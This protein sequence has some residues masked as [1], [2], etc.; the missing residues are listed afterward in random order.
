MC[1]PSTAVTD[2]AAARGDSRLPTRSSTRG[3]HRSGRTSDHG[4]SGSASPNLTSGRHR[5]ARASRSTRRVL[6]I[7]SPGS[8]RSSRCRPRLDSRRRTPAAATWASRTRRGRSTAA[9]S[10]RDSERVVTLDERSAGT[11]NGR[12]DSSG[13][14]RGESSTSDECSISSKA[15]AGT[16][17]R[18]RQ[19]RGG[20]TTSSICTR[21]RTR[22][23]PRSVAATT[24]QWAQP[25]RCGDA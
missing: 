8:R 5:R 22:L 21:T 10:P 18:C 17:G 23:F 13:F 3:R 7:V 4:R 19:R 24:L 2:D 11:L 20:R 6:N 15:P 16:A 9:T 25:G 14:R 1:D 12:R